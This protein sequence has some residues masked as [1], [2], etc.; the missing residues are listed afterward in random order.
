MMIPIQWFLN[1]RINL[2]LVTS[3][4]LSLALIITPA[5]L[6]DYVPGD[7]KPVPSDQRSDVAGPTY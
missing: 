3:C 4:A 7:Q 6:A 5:A 1:K 2:K